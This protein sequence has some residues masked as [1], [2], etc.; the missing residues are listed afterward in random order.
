MRLSIPKRMVGIASAV[1]APRPLVRTRPG[2]ALGGCRGAGGLRGSEAV[3]LLRYRRTLKRNILWGDKIVVRRRFAPVLVEIRNRGLS[4]E[5]AP[6][7]TAVG[8]AA[9][10]ATPEKG[11]TR[12]ADVTETQFRPDAICA[13]IGLRERATRSDVVWRR[14]RVGK[15][16]GYPL[17]GISDAE[18]GV[19]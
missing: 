9:T 11:G 14:D 4:P 8:T 18:F 5:G 16:I 7:G 6:E 17:E 15:G 1:C 10:S 13:L 19:R 12:P 3:Q 2:L